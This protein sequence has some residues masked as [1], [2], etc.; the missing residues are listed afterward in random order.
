MQP[1]P[2][3]HLGDL[4]D[5]PAA[6]SPLVLKDQWVNWRWLRNSNG[7]GWTKPP[8]CADYPNEYAANNNPKTWATYGAAVRTVT[9]GQ[10]HG[11]GFVLT[12]TTIGA[13]DLDHCR[14]PETGAIDSW[15][16]EILDTAPTAYR[17]VTVSGCGLRVIG[18]ATGAAQH[19]RFAVTGRLDAAVEIYRQAVRYITISG[20]EIGKCTSLPNIDGLIDGLVVRYEKSAVSSAYIFEKKDRGQRKKEEPRPEW[21][22]QEEVRVRAALKFVSAVDRQTWLHVGMA[23]HW[24]G[25]GNRARQ[26][27]DEWSRTCPEKHDEKDQT[28]AWRAFRAERDKA[29][30]IATLFDL[31]VAGGWDP[32]T[33]SDNDTAW[34]D[35]DF[36]ILDDRRG[37]LPD[38]PLDVFSPAWQ[39]WAKDAAR[40][41]GV[42]VDHVLVPLLG[43][44]ASL[45]GTARRVRPSKSWSEPFALWVAVVGFSGSGKT[46]GLSVTRNALAKIERDRKN[47]IEALRQKH[48]SDAER[49]RAIFKAWKDSVKE[50][51]EKKVPAPPMP[52]DANVPDDFVAPRL[53]ISNSTIERITVL[54]KARPRGMLMIC[55]ELAGLFLNKSNRDAVCRCRCALGPWLFLAAQPRSAASDWV[56]RAPRRCASCAEMDSSTQQDR[57]VAQRHPP[58]RT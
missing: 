6:L 37:E 53:F 13:I 49:A 45:I 1:H 5:P 51:V 35:P 38:F 27:W 31:A 15:A 30:T 17:E 48:D 52:N 9:S 33:Q 24:T 8:Y 22:Q 47:R 50:A 44:A 14:D 40:G 34:T 7:R 28:K 12:G 58:K 54:L 2:K 29:K 57:G 3:T 10:A 56:E 4:A 42:S 39:Q 43:I 21:S 46:P 16:Q 18:I 23:L 25:W 55:D 20:L 32:A 41:A 26:I 19:K 36:S 11:V